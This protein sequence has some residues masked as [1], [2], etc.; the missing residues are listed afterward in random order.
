MESKR[1]KLIRLLDRDSGLL[2]AVERDG[3][4]EST[5][6]SSS[7]IS[8]APNQKPKLPPHKEEQ[9]IITYRTL[10]SV[11]GRSRIPKGMMASEASAP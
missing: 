11:S 10:A 6:D 7:T 3:N 9:A 2:E 1:N 4:T 8:Q 5:E